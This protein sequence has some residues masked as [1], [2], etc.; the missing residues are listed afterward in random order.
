MSKPFPIT[1]GM[2]Q[3]STLSPLLYILC[4]DMVTVDIQVP[5]PWSLLFVDNIFQADKTRCWLERQV[6]NWSERLD[7]HGLCLNIKKTEY[8]VCG[9]QTDGKI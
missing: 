4:M 6:Q 1:V 2:H 5:Q 7:V 9:L 3:G 8:M